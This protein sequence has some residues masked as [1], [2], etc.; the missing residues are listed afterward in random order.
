M[1]PAKSEGGD[2]HGLECEGENEEK[3]EILQVA[4][5]RPSSRRSLLM[6]TTQSLL[7]ED[8][9]T[10]N[11]GDLNDST[12]VN[13]MDHS[14]LAAASKKKL[15]SEAPVRTPSTSRRKGFTKATLVVCPMSLLGQ[16]ISE[17]T[18]STKPGT[19]RI[20]SY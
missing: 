12:F 2:Q 16:W 8:S 17:L 7:D 18:S 9:D 10:Q 15:P 14:S 6:E 11:T 3:E 5:R 13:E 1:E 20:L 19:L 4:R